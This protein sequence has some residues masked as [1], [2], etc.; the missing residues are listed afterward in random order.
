MPGHAHDREELLALIVDQIDLMRRFAQDA[1]YRPRARWLLKE[2]VF[3]IWELPQLKE[4][5][6]GKYSLHLPWSPKAYERLAG[7]SPGAKRPPTDGLR[8]EHLIPRGILAEA[9]LTETPTDL[10]GF[11]DRHFRAAVITV[12]D[13]RQLNKAGVRARMPPGWN[14]GDDPWDRYRAAHLDPDGFVVPAERL[15]GPDADGSARA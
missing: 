14:L 10:A 8:F 1:R 5:R 15:L 2:A 13:D 3:W 4:P 12:D 11:L 6:L 7:W 9:L